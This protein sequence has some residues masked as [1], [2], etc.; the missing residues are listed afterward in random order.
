[1]DMSLQEFARMIGMTVD[2]FS[3]KILQENDKESI[4]VS[5]RLSVEDV[6]YR[7]HQLGM[8]SK[9]KYHWAYYIFRLEVIIDYCVKVKIT[10]GD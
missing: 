10:L 4:V 5:T 1:M 3:W 8:R 9:D 7:L 6:I 2:S